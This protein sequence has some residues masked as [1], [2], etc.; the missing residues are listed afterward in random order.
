MR[1]TIKPLL[2]AL[3]ALA[4][5]AALASTPASAATCKKGEAEAE[6]K[7][8]C[9]EGKQVGRTG[10]VIT[11]QASLTQKAG[12]SAVINV[13][14]QNWSVSCAHVK[15]SAEF[16]IA[17]GGSGYVKAEKLGLTLSECKVLLGEKEE[18]KCSVTLAATKPLTGSL[19]L[20]ESIEL[21]PVVGAF[22]ELDITGCTVN[23]NYTINGWQGCS[24][25]QAEVE[26]VTKELVCEAKNSHLTFA[27]GNGGPPTLKLEGSLELAGTSKGKK[28]SITK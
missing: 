12:T 7:V 4:A 2:S 16:A 17:S 21:A 11:T 6:H 25:K 15:S 24:L 19:A 27:G 10:E 5:L 18:P 14:A 22:G 3:L 23:G 8:L 1:Y 26:A 28:F 20:P 9:V 13:A